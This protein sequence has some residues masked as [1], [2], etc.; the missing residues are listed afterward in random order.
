MRALAAALL[1]A[2]AAGRAGAEAD[3]DDVRFHQIVVVKP[4]DTM[5]AIANKY[6]KDPARWDEILKHNRLPTKDP[7]V[8]LP[9]MTLRVPIR[10][11]KTHLR[12]AHLV[13]AVNRVLHRRRETADWRSS[14]LAMELFQGDTLRTLE[15][16]R[17]RVKLLDR[18]L[19]SLEPNSMAVIKPLDRDAELE[20]KS[21][22]VF[23]GH[24]RVVTDTAFVTP[25]TRDT[26]YAASIEPDLT[27]RVDVYRGVAGVRGQGSVVEVPAGMSTRVQPGLAPAAPRSIADG[28]EIESRALEYASA[29]QVGGGAAPQPRGPAG[30]ARAPEA[31]ASNLRFDLESLRVGLPIMGYRVQA[32]VD[33]DFQQTVFDKKFEAEDRLSPGDEGIKPGAYWWRISM[34]DL[35][36]TEGRFSEPRYYTV[37]IKRAASAVTSDLKHAIVVASPADDSFVDADNVRVA[38]TLRDERLRVEVSGKAARADRDGNFAVT[39]P[40]KDGVNEIIIAVFDPAGN[41][42]KISRRVTRR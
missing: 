11:I 31:D 7:T 42:T 14:A 9:G 1:L 23:A 39:V 41:S 5:W 15:E 19:L 8:A 30:L 10:L 2:V 37:G 13:Y 29:A 38:G 34:I 25:R 26:R 32:A 22:S 12:A 33:R 4:G 6:L 28:I 16:S 24:S 40:L 27:T 18:E 36:G 21:G 20:L 35:L 3:G 17:A